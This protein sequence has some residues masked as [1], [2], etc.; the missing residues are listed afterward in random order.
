MVKF[1]QPTLNYLSYPLK[2]QMQNLKN[3]HNLELSKGFLP[4]LTFYNIKS[5]N[6]VPCSGAAKTKWEFCTLDPSKIS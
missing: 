6:I 4:L 1:R 5:I 2:S 3:A